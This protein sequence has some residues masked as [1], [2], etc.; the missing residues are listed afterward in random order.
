M[1]SNHDR[2][3]ELIREAKTPVEQGILLM[4]SRFNDSLNENTRATQQIASTLE[5]SERRFEQHLEK[6]DAHEQT[7]M[8]L[9]TDITRRQDSDSATFR[10]IVLGATGILTIVIGISGFVLTKYVNS[11]ESLQLMANDL[12]R[13]VAV[14]ERTMEHEHPRGK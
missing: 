10:G 11:H 4:L 5:R 12:L 9:I 13:R 1:T 2:I 8:A 7:E 3:D 6:F 14:I